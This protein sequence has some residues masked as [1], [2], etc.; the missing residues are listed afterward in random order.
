MNVTDRCFKFWNSTDFEIKLGIW[1]CKIQDGVSNMAYVF[2][3]KSTIWH[4]IWY[5]G[6]FGVTVD[7]SEVRSVRSNM[8]DYFEHK[9]I[10]TNKFGIVLFWGCWSQF[11]GQTIKIHDGRPNMAENNNSIDYIESTHLEFCKSELEL[12][13]KN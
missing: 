3:W 10:W 5:A 11:W 9:S 12:V 7:E 2:F 4:Q 8:A 1:I 13:I 6:V